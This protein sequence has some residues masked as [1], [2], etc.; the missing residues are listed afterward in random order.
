V[1]GNEGEVLFVPPWLRYVSC[2]RDPVGA[3]HMWLLGFLS[4]LSGRIRRTLAVASQAVHAGLVSRICA[5]A[6]MTAFQVGWMVSSHALHT[7]GFAVSG[8]LV[9]RSRREAKI[10]TN[11]P[12]TAG[13]AGLK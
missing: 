6:V 5:S 2:R 11:S 13:H 3:G 10:S 4:R 9:T 1:T 7:K 12:L 8:R